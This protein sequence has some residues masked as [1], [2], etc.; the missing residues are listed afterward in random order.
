VR[1]YL[2]NQGLDPASLT[3]QGLGMSNPV[4]DNSTAEGRQRNRRIEIIVSG[5]IIGTPIGH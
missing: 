2:I 5:D 3:A 4:G 1:A